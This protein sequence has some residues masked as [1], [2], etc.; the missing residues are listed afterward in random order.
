[1]HGMLLPMM[2]TVV[3]IHHHLLLHLL[4]LAIAPIGM[5][6]MTTNTKEYAAVVTAV[7]TIVFMA[8]MLYATTILQAATMA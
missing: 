6:M 3:R 4:T 5:T 7:G 2:M 1:M 8:T